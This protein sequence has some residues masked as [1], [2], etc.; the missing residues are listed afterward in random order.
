MR[1]ATPRKR[2]DPDKEE[3]PLGPALGFLRGLWQLNQALEKVS[4]HMAKTLGVTAQQRLILRC[5]GRYP[6]ISSGQLAAL[7]HLDP[8]TISAGLRRLERKRMLD[9]RRDPRDGRRVMLSL[10]RGGRALDR[11]SAGTIEEAVEQLLDTADPGALSS[12]AEVLRTLTELLQAQM[13]R[14]R[15]RRAR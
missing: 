10:T 8:G 7:L 14:K 15:G 2:Q 13:A 5:V 11:P 1:R 12:T 6:G 3:R 4:S 9:R